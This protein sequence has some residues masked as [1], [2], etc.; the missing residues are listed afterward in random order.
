MRLNRRALM[1]G[2]ACALIARPAV[3]RTIPLSELSHFFNGFETAEGRFRQTHSDG[4][5]LGGT[6]QMRRPGRARFSYDPPEHSL[7]IAGGS[8][9]AIFDGRSNT[10]PSQYP[11]NSTPL[12]LILE[13]NV[14]FQNRRMV[15]GHGMH[16]GMTFVTLQDPDRTQH[17]SISLLFSDAPVRLQGW[18]VRD[19]TGAETTIQIESMRFGVNM[20]ASLFNITAEVDRRRR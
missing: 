11:L 10:G 6:L 3:A 4:S 15:V 14:N 12:G 20:P 16:R 18:I 9:I 13:R 1:M 5:S 2:A 17:G 7:M 8:Q 19:D